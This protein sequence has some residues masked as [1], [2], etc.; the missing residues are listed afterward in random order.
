MAM[1]EPDHKIRFSNPSTKQSYPR[2]EETHDVITAWAMAM[3]SL[4][5][6]K[7]ARRQ[8]EDQIRQ[9]KAQLRSSEERV[10]NAVVPVPAVASEKAVE[11]KR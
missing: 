11:G 3:E 9:L 7:Q 1:I 4:A 5:Q 10:R 8:A 2:L 6:T